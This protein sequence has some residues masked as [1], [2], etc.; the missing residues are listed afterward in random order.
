MNP[1]IRP[2]A[3]HVVEPGEG[4]PSTWQS[5]P[6]NGPVT[7]TE[8]RRFLLRMDR[9]FHRS[10]LTV[11]EAEN[12]YRIIE[13][14][15]PFPLNDGCYGMPPCGGPGRFDPRDRVNLRKISDGVVEIF[16]HRVGCGV[17][18]RLYRA[19]ISG[20]TLV[21]LDLLESWRETFPC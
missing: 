20:L 17:A 1:P 5:H 21:E 13:V 7:V 12:L 6:T 3:P 15:G 8:M 14:T 16:L 11:D 18:Y 2:L 10:G 4:F 9:L 19:R